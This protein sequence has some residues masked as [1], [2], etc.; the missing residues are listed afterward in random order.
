[1]DNR[2]IVINKTHC[3]IYEKSLLVDMGGEPKLLAAFDIDDST[4]NMTLEQLEKIRIDEN[5]NETN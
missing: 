5:L 1:M 3:Y 4:K 2:F